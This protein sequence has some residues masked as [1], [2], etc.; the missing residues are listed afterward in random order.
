MSDES[1]PDLRAEFN[2]LATG[3]RAVTIMFSLVLATYNALIVM[4]LFQ[5]ED[6]VYGKLAVASCDA[7]W[8]F[9]YRFALAVCSAVLPLAAGVLG[10]KTKNHLHA[11]TAVMICLV[12]MVVQMHL[13]GSALIQP[14]F[15]VLNG[16]SRAIKF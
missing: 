16:V 11:L 2:Q 9:K 8:V 5:V 7:P 13:V 3:V 4:R 1:S 10:L 14:L 15:D 12:L 6:T